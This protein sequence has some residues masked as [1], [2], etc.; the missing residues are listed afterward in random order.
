MDLVLLRI[1]NPKKGENTSVSIL[2]LMDLI[3][4]PYIVNFILIFLIYVS[5]LILMDLVL[6]LKEELNSIGFTI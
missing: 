1:K 4:L 6:L 5:I 3:L 2:I